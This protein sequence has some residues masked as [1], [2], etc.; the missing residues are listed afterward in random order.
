MW[1]VG[2][3]RTQWF[4]AMVPSA[5]STSSLQH[6]LCSHGPGLLGLSFARSLSLKLILW[7]S[8]H[9]LCLV[10]STRA[11]LRAVG[12]NSIFIQF[13]IFFSLPRD[14]VWWG[15]IFWCAGPRSEP[16]KVKNIESLKSQCP[17]FFQWSWVDSDVFPD[18]NSRV[19]EPSLS[20]SAPIAKW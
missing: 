11:P 16:L 20:P 7:S 1:V 10:V 19:T 14:R 18:V 6:H 9:S 17:V 15:N 2:H 3:A 4:S 13:I 5:Y 12:W 8:C